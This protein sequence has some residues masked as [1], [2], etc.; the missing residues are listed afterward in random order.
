MKQVVDFLTA[1]SAHND[2]EW[3]EVHKAEYKVALARFEQLTARLIEGISVFDPSVAGLSV[4][5]C[6]Y[7]IYRDVRFSHDKRPYKNY[8]GA[9]VA[10]HGKKAGWSGYYFHI[11]PVPDEGSWSGGS[12]I[13]TGLYCPSPEVLKSVREEIVD[14]GA[15][16]VS[17]VES[18]RGFELDQTAKLKRLPKDF[19]DQSGSPF[20]ELLKLKD[21]YVVQRFSLKDVLSENFLDRVLAEFRKTKALNDLLNRAVEWAMNEKEASR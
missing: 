13:S 2:R 1:L 11:E 8:M 12:L 7:R 14:N 19:A 17:A 4:K 3:F 16:I 15:A 20:E 21:I 5:D 6:T 9:Y 10:P 18:A